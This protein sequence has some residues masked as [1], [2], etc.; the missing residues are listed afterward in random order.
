[1]RVLLVDDQPLLR[2]GVRRVLEAEPDL[3][4]VGEAGHG[5][6]ALVRIAE[7][8]PELVVL[9]LNM[10][11]MDGFAVL[12]ELRARGA[13]QRVLVLSLHSDPAY[14]SRA[15]RE[16][17]DGYLLKD[18]AVQELPRAIRAVM[19]G[20]GFYSPGAQFALGEAMRATE[21]PALA[22]LTRREIEVLVA[23]AE[24]KPSK[25]IA[26]ELGIGLRTIETHRAN[27]MR[28][29]ELH[30]VAELT[31]FAIANGLIPPP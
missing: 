10:P 14:V 3:R 16:G 8:D 4:V 2:A 9:D 24:G 29:L 23:I 21:K 17:A 11:G 18:T 6:E 7:H 31:R 5:E 27:L 19:A 12:R 28:K 26:Y 20:S 25:A 13:A 30:S 1:M 22:R 15:V